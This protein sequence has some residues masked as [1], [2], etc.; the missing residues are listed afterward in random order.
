MKKV[1]VIGLDGF[2]P[3][4]VEHLLDAG[5]LPNLA[6]LRSR[7]ASH[8]SVLPILRRRL[9]R[10]Q[11]LRRVRTLVVTAFLTLFAATPKRICPIFR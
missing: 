7:A 4:L 6:Q 3:K 8:V 1:I 10:G 2:E 9:W 5:E 11:R